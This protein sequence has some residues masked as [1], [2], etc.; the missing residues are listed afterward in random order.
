VKVLFL[1]EQ[2][3]S[4]YPPVTVESLWAIPGPGGYELDN[5]PFYAR[6]IA[7]GDFV[8]VARGLDGGLEF[9]RVIRRGGHST[10]RIW[11]RQR[12]ADDP[13]YTIAQLREQGLIIESDST[14]LLAVDVPPSVSLERTEALLFAGEDSGRWGLQEGYRAGD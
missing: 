13:Q 3:E 11:L 7:L 4:G 6:G 9:D 12:R 8:G 2:D 14:G 1:L 5:I 10:Y